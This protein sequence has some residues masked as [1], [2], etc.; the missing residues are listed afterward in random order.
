MEKSEL[1]V[2]SIYEM[3]RRAYELWAQFYCAGRND[4]DRLYN[5]DVLYPVMGL[6]RNLMENEL[7]GYRGLHPGIQEDEVFSEVKGALWWLGWDLKK[8]TDV[9][10][11]EKEQ[12]E[13]LFN[14]VPADE[15]FFIEHG[16]GSFTQKDPRETSQG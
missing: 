4:R 2:S 6:I 11:Y 12:P 1:P 14:I 16:I 9:R 13:P 3:E 5:H 7:E 10:P 15:V 8:R